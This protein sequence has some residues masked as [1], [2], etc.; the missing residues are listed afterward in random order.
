MAANDCSFFFFIASKKLASIQVICSNVNPD[1]AADVK[2]EGFLDKK[3][4]WSEGITYQHIFRHSH[5]MQK[6]K[7]IKSLLLEVKKK[8]ITVIGTIFSFLL[9][10]Y[11]QTAQ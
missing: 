9:Q 11:Y 4:C 5:Y 10:K 8:E 7:L 6:R 1:L 2:Q 3:N